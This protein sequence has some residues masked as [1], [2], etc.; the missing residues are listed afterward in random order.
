VLSLTTASIPRDEKTDWFSSPWGQVQAAE[1]REQIRQ[2]AGSAGRVSVGDNFSSSL[3]AGNVSAVTYTSWI[4]EA[5]TQSVPWVGTAG[6]TFGDVTSEG[7]TCRL[8]DDPAFH[9]HV[10]GPHAAMIFGL[11]VPRARLEVSDVEV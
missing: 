2:I 9:N 7:V 5:M 8:P 6:I 10:G 11:G 4:A 1:L 3:P